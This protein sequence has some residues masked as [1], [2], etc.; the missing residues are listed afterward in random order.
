MEHIY[1]C[2]RKEGPTVTILIGN[3]N[4]RSPLFW[5]HDTETRERRVFNIFL[6]SNNL[7]EL[8]NEPT[9]FRGNARQSCIH[10][11]CTDHSYLFTDTGVL[12]SLDSHSKH[13]IIYGTLN[14]HI[15][16]LPPYK[17]KIW[18]YTKTDLICNGLKNTN[19]HDLFYN[20]NVNEMSLVFS[21]RLMEIFS[22]QICNKIIS[23]NDRDAPWIT[24][25]LKTAI[26][27]NVRVYRK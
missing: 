14:F 15:P 7:E 5:E 17:R 20:L 9:H 18:D 3:F 12:H 11:V 25:T 21:D 8:I 27:R 4:A 19:W 1:E 23:C 13:N 24:P 22:K 2:I 16:C 10:L 6:L 26:K